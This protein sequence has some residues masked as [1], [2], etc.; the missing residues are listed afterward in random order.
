[1][2]LREY[3]SFSDAFGKDLYTFISP[4]RSVTAKQSAGG[5]SPDMVREQ[6]DRFREMLGKD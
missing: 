4:S 5:T 6:I 3:R 1:M 2:D